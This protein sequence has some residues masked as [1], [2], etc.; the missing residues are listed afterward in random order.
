MTLDSGRGRVQERVA[1]GV[2]G[3]ATGEVPLD[4]TAQLPRLQSALGVLADARDDAYQ[5]A[6][7]RNLKNELVGSA[8]RKYAFLFLGGLPHMVPFLRDSGE[9]QVAEA[10]A[11]IGSLCCEHTAG[12]E[13]VLATDGVCT[14]L[15]RLWRTVEEPRVL[16]AVARCLKQ[17]YAGAPGHSVWT[18]VSE[19][20]VRAL[21]RCLRQAPPTVAIEC[22]ALAAVWAR[23]PPLREALVRAGA[24]TAILTRQRGPLRDGDPSGVP[25]ALTASPFAAVT[26]SA[27]GGKYGRS[28]CTE[29]EALAALVSDSREA[30]WEAMAVRGDRLRA[31]LLDELHDRQPARRL[32]AATI[33]VYLHRWQALTLSPDVLMVVLST[34][35]ALIRGKAS[36][37]VPPVA[38]G[39]GRSKATACRRSAH[40]VSLSAVRLL[41]RAI[42]DQPT[43]QK[44][45]FELDAYGAL[46]SWLPP[47][48]SAADTKVAAHGH[49][50]DRPCSVYAQRQAKRLAC[51]DHR[52][53]WAP[54]EWRHFVPVATAL[55]HLCLHL[56][57]AR[58]LLAGSGLL[59]RII[60]ALCAERASGT[61]VERRWRRQRRQPV[62]HA[63]AMLA[64]CLTRSTE[65]L[66]HALNDPQLVSALL[67]T[68]GDADAWLSTRVIAC[69]ALCNCA[70]WISPLRSSLLE[71]QGVERLS[72]LLAGDG[73]ALS[74]EAMDDAAMHPDRSAPRS[75][76]DDDVGDDVRGEDAPAGFHQPLGPDSLVIGALWA[77]RNLAFVATLA[78]KNT[79]LSHVGWARLVRLY[80]DSESKVVQWQALSLLRNL[81]GG[82]NAFDGKVLLAERE[83]LTLLQWLQDVLAHAPTTD[84]RVLAAICVA[85]VSVCSGAE[86][87]DRLVRDAALM[88]E[89]RRAMQSSDP[90]LRFVAAHAVANLT[91]HGR[92]PLDVEEVAEVNAEADKVVAANTTPPTDKNTERE[93]MEGEGNGSVVA[94]SPA[95]DLRGTCSDRMPGEPADT[96][97]Y[98]AARQ[99]CEQL[100]AFGIG[101][102]LRH[103]AEDDTDAD[104]SQRARVAYTQMQ[105]LLVGGTTRIA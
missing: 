90:R 67:A 70:L 42:R 7:L 99:R 60:E 44:A 79:I 85:N 20:E 18:G 91:W 28:S 34:V 97:A 29:W 92:E 12:A 57:E 105:R 23:Q 78:E 15:L 41:T 43:R 2:A 68:V 22:I 35:V 98:R 48:S 3:R 64:H 96:E 4:V 47:E 104:V 87:Q 61:D 37:A 1:R 81:T 100:E 54:S 36:A 16:E 94:V 53:S 30:A 80:Y 46:T 72:A 27:A 59:P 56:E 14:S 25:P 75:S 49:P 66:K 50:G 5:V 58:R 13:A 82:H 11:I 38:D 10:C 19:E 39:G 84:M 8:E 89:L 74:P 9:G 71:M 52:R 40:S 24:I 88:T 103:L 77:L 33:L 65:N 69:A 51:V 32:H 83:P 86:C 76:I 101:G 31:Q 26:A 6:A 55:T 93:S 62:R 17:V 73:L 95:D 21:V 102:Q 63:A 45:A